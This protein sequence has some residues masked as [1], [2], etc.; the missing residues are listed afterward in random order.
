MLQHVFIFGIFVFLLP[1]V[2]P[3]PLPDKN[4]L[5]NACYF[6]YRVG[7]VICDSGLSPEDAQHDME[8]GK[9]NQ[10]FRLMASDF[11]RRVVQHY[12]EGRP[13]PLEE[14]A[15]LLN[16]PENFQQRTMK[17]C[18]AMQIV[19]YILLAE[20]RL[21]LHGP[22]PSSAAAELIAVGLD[23]SRIVPEDVYASLARAWP[24]EEALQRF[25][26]T[27]VSLRSLVQQRSSGSFSFH[28]VVCRCQ[29]DLA[30]LAE[31]APTR[32]SAI[33]L[34]VYDACSSSPGDGIAP[35]VIAR[36]A[37][38]HVAPASQD[39]LGPSG[40]CASH[41]VFEHLMA[42]TRLGDSGDIPRGSVSAPSHVAFISAKTPE[43]P[44]RHLLSLVLQSAAYQTLDVDFLPL[45][46]QRSVPQA[47]TRCVLSIWREILGIVGAPSGYVGARFVANVSHILPRAFEVRHQLYSNDAS[48]LRQC[49]SDV[50]SGRWNDA[51]NHAL[52]CAWHVVF[53]RD[54]H[55][56][57]RADD[58]SLPMFLR[59]ADGPSG[60]WN[61][62]MPKTSS[63][64]ANVGVGLAPSEQ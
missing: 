64:L 42:T 39:A 24:M 57:L 12:F 33:A 14:A 54:R 20:A 48:P 53:G 4:E 59:F 15:W 47:P 19:A 18:A 30:W 40:E 17:E 45:A 23:Q 41:A 16:A 21:F 56:P 38:V 43:E 9:C 36:F 26:M 3:R 29:E 28:I 60:F 1:I 8:A 6:T 63:Y 61:T 49:Q 37:D 44:E 27:S 22:S 11:Q 13:P 5:A 52:M 51:V 10:D 35:E 58:E 34:F 50:E 7:Y 62:R 2:K 46:L 55:Q 31:S 25:Q 32:R